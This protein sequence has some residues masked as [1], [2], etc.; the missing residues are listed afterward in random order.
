[1]NRLKFISNFIKGEYLCDVGTD[2]GYLP[3]YCFNQGK[4]KKA[5][6]IDNKLMPLEQAKKN[7]LKYKEHCIFSLS[8]GLSDLCED[9]DVISICG[10]GADLIIK[11]LDQKKESLYNKKIILCANK[12]YYKL[13][14]YLYLNNFLI[15]DEKVVYDKFYYEIIICKKVHIL[16]EQY[17]IEELMFGKY[18]IND[19]SNLD[20]FCYQYDILNKIKDKNK[21]AL[22]KIFYLEKIIKNN[23][24]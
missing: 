20:Y 15:Q 11:I 23:K 24:N 10:M 22:E 14:K 1:M 5:Q 18:L 8:N 9:V 12:N 6:L 3:L 13:R 19:K 2:H 17:K 4:I 7:L 21:N 16:E